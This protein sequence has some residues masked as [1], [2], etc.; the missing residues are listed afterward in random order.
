MRALALEGSGF[1]LYDMFPTRRG[2]I[3]SD[4]VYR[5][6][7]GHDA[8]SKYTMDTK[9]DNVGS[10]NSPKL[11]QNSK[12]SQNDVVMITLQTRGSGDFFGHSSTPTSK[13]AI[14]LEA[15]V[16]ATGPTYI[17]VVVPGGKFEA[18]FGPAPNN[19]GPSGRG[20]KNMRLRIDRYFSNIPYNRMI[21]ALGQISAIPGQSASARDSQKTSHPSSMV[22]GSIRQTILSTFAFEDP[23]S[24]DYHNIEACKLND[25]SRF[26]A[27]P[28]LQDSAILTNQVLGFF[29]QNTGDKFP[30]FNGPQLSAIGAALTRKLTLIQ[31]P[32]GTGK[33]TVAAA[34]CFGF[35]HQCRAS[36]CIEKHSKV[37]ATA[38]SNAGADNMAESLL[39]LGLKV[40]RVG[41]ASAVSHSLWEYTL[42]AAISRD[43]DAQKALEEASNATANLRSSGNRKDKKGASKPKLD[44]SLERNKRDYATKAVKA[45]IEVSDL[46]HVSPFCINC[47]SSNLLYF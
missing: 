36:N 10:E 45:S 2:N 14:T 31:G 8:A 30:N 12:F 17:D 34:I 6:V 9:T 40:V 3:F 24:P 35:V 23:S 32:P 5:L 1:A 29:Q 18:T 43:P 27:R 41:K 7:K 38:F 28:P 39:R 42:D 46:E 15:R 22:D 21:A 19:T 4:E 13:D 16:I 33:T 47:L 26:I 25:L 20:D 37:L 11:P 44:M